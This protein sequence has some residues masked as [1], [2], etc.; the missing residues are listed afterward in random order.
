MT[1]RARIGFVLLISACRP[2]VTAVRLD[3]DFDSRVEIDQLRVIQ[4]GHS[5]LVPGERQSIHPP[6]TVGVVLDDDTAKI[7]V[8]FIVYGLL[9]NEEKVTG[10]VNVRPVPHETV[11]ATVM[12]Q[13]SLCGNAAIYDWNSHDCAPVGLPED[14][15]NNWSR[16]G[17]SCDPVLPGPEDACEFEIIGN[18]DCEP[19]VADWPDEDPGSVSLASG[20]SVQVAIDGGAP[21]VLLETGEYLGF[22]IDRPVKV[23]AARSQDVIIRGSVTVAAGSAGPVVVSGVRIV[24]PATGAGPDGLAVAGAQMVTV[25]NVEVSGFDNGVRIGAPVTIQ[26]SLVK[27]NGDVG[28]LVEADGTAVL[29]QVVVRD[30][31][32]ATGPGGVGIRVEGGSLTTTDS[33]IVHNR[34]HGLDVDGASADLMT[35]VVGDTTP[36]DATDL[37]AGIAV[38]GLSHVTVQRSLVRDNSSVGVYVDS[39]DAVVA[40]QKT[41]IRNT[42]TQTIGPGPPWG[43]GLA[44]SGAGLLG[45]DVT[46]QDGLITD[47]SVAG[48]LA[49]LAQGT[50]AASVMA[51][52]VALGGSIVRQTREAPQYGWGHGLVAIRGDLPQPAEHPVCG[53]TNGPP[54]EIDLDQSIVSDNDYSGVYACGTVVNLS[55]CEIIRNPSPTKSEQGGMVNQ[56]DCYVVSPGLPLTPTPR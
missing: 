38:R 40:L 11:D 43:V 10:Y 45:A 51:P 3:I 2:Q 5:V 28:I 8:T 16:T 29:D 56:V 33:L 18:M 7:D 15:W 36:W 4:R 13:P 24:A 50:V 44:V 20:Q 54:P 22:S 39:P 46:F 31:S 12:L 49:F 52:H 30:P 35:T 25:K 47:N 26:H 1:A 19:L 14:C 48:I 21:Q 6:V 27:G 55:G 9:L 32:V 37:A 53:A 23:E 17:E 41:Q 34:G 42:D